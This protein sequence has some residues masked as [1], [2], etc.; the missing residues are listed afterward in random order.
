MYKTLEKYCFIIKILIKKY[1]HLLQH[2][3]TPLHY[4]SLLPDHE[5]I[6]RQLVDAGSATTATDMVSVLWILFLI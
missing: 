2:G 6:Y 5:Q 4:A 1:C 3:R